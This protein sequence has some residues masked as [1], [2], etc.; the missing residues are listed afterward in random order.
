MKK[1]TEILKLKKQLKEKIL[2]PMY[3]FYGE[4]D[5]FFKLFFQF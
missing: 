3:I 2:S 1:N 5:F 4:E